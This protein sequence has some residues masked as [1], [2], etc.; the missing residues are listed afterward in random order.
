MTTDDRT[1]AIL[2]KGVEVLGGTASTAF[3]LLVGGPVGGLVGAAVSPVLTGG[4]KVVAD[5]AHRTLSS[6]EE[7]R[8]GT[9]ALHTLSIIRE[10]LESGEEVR[11]KALFETSGT[12][13]PP[14]EQL[15]EGVLLTCRSTFEEKKLPF[16]A[17]IFANAPFLDVSPETVHFV[18]QLAERVTFQELCVAALVGR[19]RELG[20]DTSLLKTDSH[21]TRD[22]LFGKAPI[23]DLQRRQ[24]SITRAVGAIGGNYPGMLHGHDEESG[25]GTYKLTDLG[26]TVFRLMGLD[27]VPIADLEPMMELLR[28]KDAQSSTTSS[29]ESVR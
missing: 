3:G 5:M 4:L 22:Q 26:E 27:E 6:R 16:I 7:T 25:F 2:E 11:N 19:K 12:H 17:N 20:F 24:T 23:S 1:K 18:I 15:F 28:T 8:L 10:R 14:A 21:L 13:T 9:A 29:P